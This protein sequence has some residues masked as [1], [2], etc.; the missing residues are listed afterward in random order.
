V[1]SKEG[2]VSAAAT[3]SHCMDQAW[4][5]TKQPEPN[6]Y[7]GGLPESGI[8]QIFLTLAPPGVLKNAHRNS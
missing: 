4:L 5:G 8:S 6:I 3:H 1:N 2:K 7:H